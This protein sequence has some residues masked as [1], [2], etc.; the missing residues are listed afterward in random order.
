MFAEAAR[1]EFVAVA[2][3]SLEAW[4]EADEAVTALAA[5]IL[6]EEGPRLS[7]V[8]LGAVDFAGHALGAGRYTP[9]TRQTQ[10][11]PLV[12]AALGWPLGPGLARR[13]GPRRCRPRRL[14]QRR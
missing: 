6:A 12:L 13:P 8:Y 3:V 9:V 11:A 14:L 2:E 10:I 7:F 1:R 4:E 5:K